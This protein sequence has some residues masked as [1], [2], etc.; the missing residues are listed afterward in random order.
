MNE[1]TAPRAESVASDAPLSDP[2]DDVLGYASFAENLAKAIMK[3]PPSDGLVLAVFGPWG[4]GKSTVLNFVVHH[5]NELSDEQQPIIVRFN[6]WWFAGQEDL[7][8]RFFDQL[9]VEIHRWEMQ[10]IASDQGVGQRARRWLAERRQPVAAVV[11]KIAALGQAFSP[12]FKALELVGEELQG[13]PKGVLQAKAAAGEALRKLHRPIVVLMDDIDRLASD[14]IRDIFRLIKAVGDLRHV[15]YILALDRNV[16]TNALKQL[17]SADIQ[18]EVVSG[19]D[20]LAKIVQAGFDLPQIDRY[21]LDRLLTARLDKIIADTPQDM[22]DQRY[23]AN[24][25]LQGIRHFLTSP[26][27]VG[28]LCNALAVTY[29]AVEGEVNPVDFIAIE[30]L[31]V[32]YPVL[33]DVIRDSSSQFIGGRLGSGRSAEEAELAAFHKG[34]LDDLERSNRLL[35]EPVRYLMSELFPKLKAIWDNH[36]YDD[37]TERELRKE[38]HVGSPDFFPVYFRLAVPADRISTGRMRALLAL[39][40]NA[41]AF[42]TELLRLANEPA[43]SGTKA[44]H[45]LGR[46]EE[47]TESGIPAGHIPSVVSAM[48]DAGDQLLE[49]QH[50]RQGGFDFG[51]HVRI[52]RVSIQLLR[53][54]PEHERFGVLLATMEHSRSLSTIVDFVISLGLQHGKY[55]EKSPD[56]DERRLVTI[57]HL[58]ALEAV[59]VAKITHAAESDS[60]LSTPLLVTVLHFWRDQQGEEPVKKWT[61]DAVASDNGLATFLERFLGRGY[62]SSMGELTSEIYYRLDPKSVS[63]FIE[64]DVIIA[65]VRQMEN[66][67]S[68]TGNQRLAARQFVTDY[69]LRAKGKDPSSPFYE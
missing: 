64:P 39:G 69:E 17:N 20:Y 26:R 12:A 10:Q 32:L 3:A 51:N 11:G 40:N 5:L 22:F 2:K 34:W 48:F 16:A 62:K 31:R 65:R 56:P 38:C 1:S 68:L 63:P 27:D 21:D 36:V 49:P 58:T 25:Y 23:W 43:R 61:L 29:P 50:Q 55:G 47:F 53:R 8:R 18:K 14:E 60:L 54:L 19:E 7:T 42:S 52:A 30:T 59:A 44:A 13:A 28:R 33:Y 24:L 66:S 4:S 9:A 46:L 6:P 35:V 15:T 41:P 45:L 57:E 37:G 67:A